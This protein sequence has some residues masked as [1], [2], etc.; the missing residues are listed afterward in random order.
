MNVYRL[1]GGGR[2]PI[3][4]PLTTDIVKCCDEHLKDSD[5]VTPKSTT[6]IGHGIEETPRLHV[7]KKR[8]VVERD[9]ELLAEMQTRKAQVDRLIEIEERKAAAF[10]KMVNC[11][12]K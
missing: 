8:K 11:F 5:A 1:S 12:T 3:P 7:A 4:K 10:E 6:E 9:S 2:V